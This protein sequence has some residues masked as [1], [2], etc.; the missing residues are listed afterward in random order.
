MR[1]V[2]QLSFLPEH[3]LESRPADPCVIV[4]L[5]STM[6]ALEYAC[7]LAK[8]V[9]KR[10]YPFLKNKDKT[11]WSRICSGERD[12]QARDITPFNRVVGNSAY[13]LYLNHVDGWDIAMM[14]KALDDKDRRIA[15][16]EQE[17]ADYRRSVRLLVQA[18][19]TP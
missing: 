11:A 2:E 18:K 12:I 15:E 4:G 9:P 8:A 16:L 3:K 7:S 13:L 5:Q 6:E 10:V 14:R 1:D 17:V 19:V